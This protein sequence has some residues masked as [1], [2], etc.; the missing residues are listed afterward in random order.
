MPEFARLHPAVTV[1]LGLSDRFVDLVEEG[2]DLAVR[3]GRMEDSSMVA[4]RL[5]PCRMVACAS[6]GY[7]AGHGRPA[8]VRDLA[9]HNCLSY[10]LS[11]M[12]S[13]GRW[14]FG[15]DGRVSVPVSGNLRANSG[16]ALVAAA[17]AGQGL[18][19]EPTFLVADALR[20]GRLAAV[21]LDEPFI[22]LPGIYAVH[23]ASRLAPAK[24]RAF[25][26]LLGHRFAGVPPWDRRWTASP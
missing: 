2:W 6:P 10:T 13:G 7:L 9:G 26:A 25:V 16:D 12:Q 4:R 20:D 3:I 21:E 1:D 17:I 5:A 11:R 18:I 8:T 15:P 14:L 23:P 24:V 22:E 19:Y